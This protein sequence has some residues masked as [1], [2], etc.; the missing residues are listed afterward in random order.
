MKFPWPL[1]KKLR[2]PRRKFSQNQSDRGQSW[3]FTTRKLAFNLSGYNKYGLY[4]HDVILMYDHPVVREAL[5]R[6]PLDV[7]DAR[8]FRLL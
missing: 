1:M 3:D 4:T 5:R 8:N 7:L 2:L 6:L